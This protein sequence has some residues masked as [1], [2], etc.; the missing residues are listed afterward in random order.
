MKISQAQKEKNRISLLQ[1]AVDVMAKEG[2]RQSTMKAIAQTAKLSEPVIYKYFPTK[3]SLLYGYFQWRLEQAIESLTH[4]E[5]FAGYTFA[6]QI[7]ALLEFQLEQFTPD[8][9]FVKAAYNSI[10]V[11][12]LSGSL[13]DLQHQ[14]Q[15]YLHFIEN[16]LA[17]AVH[18]KEFSEPPSAGLLAELLW[19]YH[20]GIVYYW[21]ND[22]SPGFA[23]TTQLID[24]SLSLFTEIL[25]SQILSR[26]MDIVYFLVR[27]HLFKGFALLEELSPSQRAAKR[28]FYQRQSAVSK[29]KRKKR[30]S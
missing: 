16:A 2:V 14:K 28:D 20:I 18:A 29:P 4:N 8:R 3:E 9:E 13:T 10:F 22:R 5:Q 1:A 23:N 6:E 25:R 11:S 27:Q 12:T 30:E 19:D 26:A 15:I 17:A 7:Q 21:L 24:K